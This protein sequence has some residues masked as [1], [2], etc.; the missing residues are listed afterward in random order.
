MRCVTTNPPK[1]FTDASITATV[2]SHLAAKTTGST[3][4]TTIPNTANTTTSSL[5]LANTALTGPISK[6]I[7]NGPNSA[8]SGGNKSLF[9]AINVLAKFNQEAIVN[10]NNNQ[11]QNQSNKTGQLLVQT[12]TRY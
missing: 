1:I 7:G 11:P 2:N 12:T 5:L 8:A 3:T 10:N 4:T 9:D 6:L